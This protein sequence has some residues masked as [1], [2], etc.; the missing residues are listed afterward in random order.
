MSV[1][2]RP[3]IPRITLGPRTAISPSIPGGQRAARV[4]VEDRH[5]DPLEGPTAAA[6]LVRGQVGVEPEAAVRPEGLGHAEEVGPCSGLGA[7]IRGQ[8]GGEAP[9]SEAGEVGGGEV[10]DGRRGGPPGRAIPGRG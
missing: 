5:L 7:Q 3:Q 1:R 6:V 9:R 4:G 10:R 8:D 2:V